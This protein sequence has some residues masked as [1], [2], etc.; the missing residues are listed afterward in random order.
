MIVWVKTEFELDVGAQALRWVNRGQQK[1]T[2]HHVTV[3]ALNSTQLNSQFSFKFKSATSATMSKN[4]SRATSSSSG[5]PPGYFYSFGGMTPNAGHF[6]SSPS[7]GGMYPGGNGGED[8]Y[9]DEEWQKILQY[10]VFQRREVPG[11]SSTEVEWW[12]KKALNDT[13]GGIDNVKEV[14]ANRASD[15][16]LPTVGEPVGTNFI[17]LDY[18]CGLTKDPHRPMTGHYHLDIPVTRRSLSTLLL[19][20]QLH[21]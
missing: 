6:N 1:S 18:I 5:F 17:L 4:S 14:F 12:M 11:L 8:N 10:T 7:F 16:S 13:F 2:N 20:H 21:R 3:L 9:D 19:S 15:P